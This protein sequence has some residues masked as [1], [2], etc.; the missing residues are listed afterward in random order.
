[1][2]FIATKPLSGHRWRDL[3]AADTC[4]LQPR[5]GIRADRKRRH[6]AP[7]RAK[8]DQT[9]ADSHPVL[10][11]GDRHRHGDRRRLLRRKEPDRVRN[12]IRADAWRPFHPL[13]SKR[14]RQRPELR[15]RDRK[16]ARCAVFA[17]ASRMSATSRFSFPRDGGPG[18]AR[19]GPAGNEAAQPA[20]RGAAPAWFEK[21]LQQPPIVKTY[22][23]RSPA[24][25]GAKS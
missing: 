14:S 24:S 3:G 1:M 21:L 18:A 4:Q 23:V 11:S 5:A 22:P 10:H 19:G 7:N 17:R 16:P 9:A 15:R 8:L 2:H 20:R 25:S 12:R 6:A 13:R